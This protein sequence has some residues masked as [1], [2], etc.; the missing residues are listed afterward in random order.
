MYKKN[1]IDV[2]FNCVD[3]HLYL[4]KL[5]LPS[6]IKITFLIKDLSLGGQLFIVAHYTLAPYPPEDRLNIILI[7]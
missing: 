5:S 3:C 1:I 4:I 6:P 2:Q 7:D